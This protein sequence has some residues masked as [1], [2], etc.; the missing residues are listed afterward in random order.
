M[1]KLCA[2]S[3]KELREGKNYSEK[4][5][6][7]FSF[8]TIPI[9]LQI[10]GNCKCQTSHWHQKKPRDENKWQW[11]RIWKTGP[12]G[13][14]TMV[15]FDEALCSCFQAC[16]HRWGFWIGLRLDVGEWQ[17][18]LFWSNIKKKWFLRPV[19]QTICKVSPLSSSYH[20]SY[21]L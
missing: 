13:N 12:A 6:K 21:Y 1:R 9:K 19:L 4:V 17:F 10:H 5:P 16:V 18:S 14:T 20:S 7:I 2:C 11:H 15:F 8:P 3:K